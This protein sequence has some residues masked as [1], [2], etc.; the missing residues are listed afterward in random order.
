VPLW[1]RLQQASTVS[2]HS[3]KKFQQIIKPEFPL[4]EI[5]FIG[6]MIFV[7]G[8]IIRQILVTGEKNYFLLLPIVLLGLVF[9]Y[10][11]TNYRNKKIQRKGTEL[12]VNPLL[13]KTKR[14]NKNNIQGYEIYE[15]Y[16]RTGL[17][18]QIRLIDK[19]GK[20][21]VFARDAYRDYDTLIQMI[22]NCGF[23]NLGDREIN[24]R[25]KRQY[26]LVVSISFILAIIMFFLLKLIEN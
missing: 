26:G 4:I 19:K 21:T 11:F 2:T 15:T 25:Y 6:F 12:I 20:K 9:G 14:F 1:P 8:I 18:R 5:T 13:S 22:K 10:F 24:W 16:N 7:L 23:E 17:I 3:M